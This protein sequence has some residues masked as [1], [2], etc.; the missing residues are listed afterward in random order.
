M[1]FVD[2]AHVV[3]LHVARHEA[4]AGH[5]AQLLHDLGDGRRD[6]VG[7]ELK[8]KEKQILNCAILSPAATTTSSTATLLQKLVKSPQML[9]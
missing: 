8:E 7:C 3:E 6:L 4:D 1:A 9:T 2:K 5:L